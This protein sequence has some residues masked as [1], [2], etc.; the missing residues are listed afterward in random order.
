MFPFFL[1]KFLFELLISTW[2]N[3]IRMGPVYWV[4]LYVVFKFRSFIL[5]GYFLYLEEILRSSDPLSFKHIS[6]VVSVLQDLS[7]ENKSSGKNLHGILDGMQWILLH[8]LPNKS[9]N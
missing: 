2:M 4:F 8:D 6:I 1:V 7:I 5:H 9:C 3:W